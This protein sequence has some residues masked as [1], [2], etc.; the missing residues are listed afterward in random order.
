LIVPSPFKIIFTNCLKCEKIKW[1]FEEK[2]G[3]QNWGCFV[4]AILS[5]HRVALPGET[6]RCNSFEVNMMRAMKI[7]LACVAVLVAMT[8]PASAAAIFWG[9]TPYLSLGDIPVG[10]YAGGLPAGLEDFEDGDL[11][12]GILASAGAVIPPGFPGLIDSVDGD[13]GVI[14]GSGLAGHS[15]FFGTGSTGVT[16]TFTG[17]LPTAAG[18]V[19]TDGAGAT[20]FEAFGP[21]MVSLGIYLTRPGVIRLQI[22][23]N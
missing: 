2:P 5:I 21:G 14:D 18:I 23:G 15:W 1:G 16:F 11:D 4:W 8:T 7:G 6:L 17:P 9:L 19:W 13:D 10:F 12:F 22:A 3:F 20:T